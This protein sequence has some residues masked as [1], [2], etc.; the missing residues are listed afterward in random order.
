MRLN[1][2]RSCRSHPI[3][4]ETTALGKPL[5]A[6]R[7][8]PGRAALLVFLALTWG[9]AGA[10][11]GQLV[12]VASS[13]FSPP[14]G[15][16][17]DSG[18][19]ILSPDGRFVLFTST[20]E[21][22][23]VTS[24]NTPYHASSLP[25][26]NVFL[27]DRTNGTTTLV[28]RNAA[29]TGGGNG[30]SIGL[31]VSTN[32]R[33]ALLESSASDLV[34]DDTNGVNDIFVRD[35]WAGTT[36]LVSISTNGGA[37]NGASREAVLTPDGRCVA[38]VSLAD[39]LVSDDTNGLADVFVADLQ[40][41]TMTLASVGALSSSAINGS[42]QPDITP[43]GRYVAFY[44]T[45]TNL[46]PGADT[47]GEIY[48]RDLVGGVTLWASADA[49]AELAS[50]MGATNAVLSYH[51]LSADGKYVVFQVS[52]S[53]TSSPP[54]PQTAGLVLR[55]DL[56]TA[57]TAVVNTNANMPAT[58]VADEARRLDM[59]PDGRFVVF[60]AN[61]NG[62]SG[63]EVCVLVWDGVTGQ[64]TLASGDLGAAIAADDIA[65]WP[66]IDSTGRYVAFL[67][68]G[69]NNLAPDVPLGSYHLYVKDLQ[70]GT[71]KVAD[72]G[73]NGV[74]SGVSYATLSRFSAGGR[75]IAFVAPDGNLVAGDW[76]R[77][78]DVFVR[79]LAADTT[80]LI[81][82]RAPALPSLSPSGPT[83]WSGLSVSADGRYV[84]FTSLADDLALNDT[85]RCLDV[86][87][88]DVVAGV[89]YLVSVATNGWSS[90]N[91]NSGEP[92]LSADGRY[93]AFSSGANNLV[94]NDYN[95]LRDVFVRD[96]LTG[97]TTLVSVKTNPVASGNGDSY[98]PRISA[99]GQRV[100]F[101]STAY[102]LAPVVYGSPAPTNLFYRDLQSRT[103]SV[104][105]VTTYLGSL[106]TLGIPLD[107]TMTPD[108]RWVAFVT[109]LSRFYVWDAQS[110]LRVYTNSGA[111]STR[112]ALSPDGRWLAFA[113]NAGSVGGLYLR[114]LAFGTNRTVSGM[115]PSSRSTLR[116]SADG[117][118]LAY[119]CTN[120]LIPPDTNATYDVFL[121]DL[122]T[123]SHL[124]VSQGYDVA[125]A[126]NGASDY[127]DLS[128]DGRFVAYRSAATNLIASDHNGATD[129]FLYDRLTGAT[130]LLSVSRVDGG[131]GSG[132]SCPPRF[133]ADGRRLVFQS[134]A[135]DL[136]AFDFNQS[137]DVF[138]YAMFY[139]GIAP[140][141]L[142]ASGPTLNWPAESGKTYHVEYLDDLR[143]TNWHNAGGS[144]TIVGDQGYFTD[145]APSAGQRFYRIVAE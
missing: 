49:R 111:A 117:R 87:V 55:Y 118:Y 79:D 76:N 145:P 133:T 81:S 132:W 84:A 105:T 61:T 7:A 24:S 115:I 134:W 36:R 131:P 139:A 130:K 140:G 64:T 65:G 27:R 56:Q 127:P 2:E 4:A 38:F 138:A 35:L 13:A 28:S 106:Y 32:G 97:T 54:P 52:P 23:S 143:Q 5:P 29:G 109:G 37:A 112:V 3:S 113:T 39:N 57:L 141:G 44:S 26:L 51:A 34:P 80:E 128:P 96:L 108:G 123:H 101:Q 122:Q 15:G 126:A 25:R 41:N 89:N 104:L 94:T 62:T 137:G 10:D 92:S 121:Y 77:A 100:L 33:Y 63:S 20:A 88:R 71:T 83:F 103:T 110:G 47:A 78:E 17:G 19:P 18:A 68:S 86:Y 129:V 60:V 107:T 9:G 144:V 59:T 22:L 75:F 12:S 50:A 120:A 6:R 53:V 70:A 116:F 99:D 67:S 93:V 90:T 135:S 46:V 136:A 142:P 72:T 91:A 124:L 125:G 43:D 66:T 95:P 8:R 48:V 74:L 102:N 45:A 119:S 82:A 31:D 69:T 114:D 42:E 73:T 85:N 21:N 30:D 58:F 40:A 14:S 98:Q 1:A 11:A 16:G